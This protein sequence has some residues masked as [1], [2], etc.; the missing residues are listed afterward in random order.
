MSGIFLQGA[1]T[2]ISFLMLR[3][4]VFSKATAWVGILAHG[5]DLAHI[6]FIVFVPLIGQWLMV[7]AGP[8]YPVWFFMVGRRLLQLG[9]EPQT[10]A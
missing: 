4:R 8:L 2:L 3:S 7:I 10:E 5:F 6:L 1:T 9:K